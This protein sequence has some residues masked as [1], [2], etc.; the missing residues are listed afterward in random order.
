M[1]NSYGDLT[2][3]ELLT[4][5]EELHKQ[6]RDLRFDAVI[7]HVENPLLRRTLRRSLARINTI[8]REYELG[9]RES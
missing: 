2:Y 9:I 1:K 7:G 6:Y 5:R 8:V 4:R 3:G